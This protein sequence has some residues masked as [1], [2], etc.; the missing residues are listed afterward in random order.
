MQ[1]CYE[2]DT[3][4]PTTGPQRPGDKRLGRSYT[5]SVR[6]GDP[7]WFRSEQ[8]THFLEAAQR[9]GDTR[10][11]RSYNTRVRLRDPRPVRSDEVTCISGAAVLRVRHWVP[12]DGS[13]A[14]RRQTS[15][16]QLYYERPTR[17]PT[18]GPQRPGDTLLGSS[19]NTRF[20]LG[21]PQRARSDQVTCISVTSILR[22]ADWVPHDGSAAIRRQTSRV[23][24][25]YE[26]PTGRPAAGSQRPGDT[27]LGSSYNTRVRL[28]DPR[29]VRSDQVTCISGAAVLRVRH[30]VPHDGSPLPPPHR[31][32]WGAGARARAR[33]CAQTLEAHRKPRTPRNL[34]K[35]TGN[36]HNK[37][38]Q[39]APP[40]SRK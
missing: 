37:R 13:A 40:K 21:D 27:R 9:P 32:G 2:S 34:W 17:R 24:L 16:A 10:L 25:Y 12:H 33:A 31:V 5:T 15:R 29:R 22:V 36:L 1:L 35:P 20:G 11:G 3:G 18:V 6:P 28:R 7:R 19:Y 23:Q 39:N 38:H 14:T 26:R 30:W 4:Y 8:A